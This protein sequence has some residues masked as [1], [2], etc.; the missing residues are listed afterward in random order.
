[1]TTLAEQL[2]RLA[3]EVNPFA[4]PPC[5]ARTKLVAWNARIKELAAAL[6]ATEAEDGATG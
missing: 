3:G 1:M 2:E 5:P 6:R 4:L